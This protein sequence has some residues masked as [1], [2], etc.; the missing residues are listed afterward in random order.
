LI[1]SR[2]NNNHINHHLNHDSKV[3][4]A[5]VI[6]AASTSGRRYENETI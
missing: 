2:V 1:V 5:E 6:I 4:K 3:D